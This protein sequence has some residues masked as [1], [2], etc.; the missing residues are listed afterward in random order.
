MNL[1]EN[2]RESL[3]AINTN[4]LRTVLTAL[5]I[6][7]GITSLVGILTAID[8]IQYS[9]TS[10]LSSLGA[11]SFDINPKGA[12]GRRGG[13]R[14][15]E[16]KVYPTISYA[17]SSHFKELYNFPATVSIYLQVSGNAEIKR[18]SKK[19]NPNMN[20][21]GGDENYLLVKGFDLEKGRNFSNIEAQNGSNVVIIG[22]ETV[23]TLF[24]NEEPLN[25]EIS[26]YGSRFKV[27]GVL[28]K[29][30]NMEGG[31]SDRS[32]II[33]TETARRIGTGN[34][35]FRISASVRN[36]VEM[37]YA[38]GEA[39]GLMRSIRQDRI[40]REDSFEIKKSESL[41]ERLEETSGY[42]RIGGFVIGF[43]T[44]LGAS[45]GLMNIM[46]VSVTE[47]T[48]EI[49]VR[50]ALGATP[51]RIRQQFLIEAIVICL[52]GGMAGVLLGISIGNLIANLI[53]KGTFIVPWVWMVAGLV[54]CIFVGLVSGYYPAKKAAK[55]DPIEALR[56]E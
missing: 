23:I 10:S 52:I 13:Q 27:V 43:I 14:G 1:I 35:R 7:I 37:E 49:G 24:E 16:D 56:F 4:L 33:P 9:I 30:G 2:I 6:A 38:I 15:V 46:M 28:E 48:R 36:P 53:S 11:N 41:A 26:F 25:K 21:M 34:L 22:N 19:T 44:L 32:V 12:D 45:I 42:L 47:R 29:Q 5:I 18:L 3:R 40:G 31:G 17:E 55:L 50:K 8:A 20:I 39:T 54:I 51:L